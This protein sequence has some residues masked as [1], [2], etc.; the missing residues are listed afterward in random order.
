[1][2]GL[3]TQVVSVVNGD[4]AKEYVKTFREGLYNL[5]VGAAQA[6]ARVFEPAPS[7]PEWWPSTSR[8]Q[9]VASTINLPRSSEGALDWLDTFATLDPSSPIRPGGP[10][11]FP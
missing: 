8:S 5:G 3:A 10:E 1:V 2:A 4:G 6:T 9:V 11:G 7:G